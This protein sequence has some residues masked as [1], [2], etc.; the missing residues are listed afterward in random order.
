MTIVKQG[1][2][3]I[4]T[5]VTLGKLMAIANSL[6]TSKKDGKLSIVG[7]DV[8][9]VIDQAIKKEDKNIG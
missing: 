8:L 1:D 2:K 4:L 5:G 3:F 6:N 7:E 9:S